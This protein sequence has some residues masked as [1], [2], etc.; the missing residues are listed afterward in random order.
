MTAVAAPIA[1]TKPADDGLPPLRLYEVAAI[2]RIQVEGRGLYDARERAEGYLRPALAEAPASG[3]EWFGVQPVDVGG[4]DYAVE[5]G[6]GVA[7]GD[8][9]RGEQHDRD[10]RRRNAAD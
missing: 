8:R 3:I 1:P 9:T 2:V 4:E 6:E 10:G 7:R 5:V